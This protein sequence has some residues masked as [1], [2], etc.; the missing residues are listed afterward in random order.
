MKHK[1][2]WLIIILVLLLLFALGYIILDKYTEYQVTEKTQIYQLGVEEGY[3]L[4]IAQLIESAQSCQPVPLYYGNF[5]VNMIA[6]E[7]LQMSEN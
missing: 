2:N 7:C 6:V 5:T 3:S 4:A 1:H